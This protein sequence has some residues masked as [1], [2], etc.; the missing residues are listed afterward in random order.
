MFLETEASKYIQEGD[1]AVIKT[2]DDTIYYLLKLSSSVFH[3]EARVTDNYRYTFPLAQHFAE[4]HYLEI[5][6]DKSC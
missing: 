3:N 2:S 4:G 5:Q 1:V 6:R